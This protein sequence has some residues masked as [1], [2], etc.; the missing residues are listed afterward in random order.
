MRRDIYGE[1]HPATVRGFAN[2]AT[3]MGR[4]GK[5]AEA[6]RLFRGLIALRSRATG[7]GDRELAAFRANLS[8]VLRKLGRLDE[9]ERVAR[10]ALDA[11]PGTSKPSLEA[12]N[13]MIALASLPTVGARPRRS[14]TCATASRS[15][16]SAWAP[17]SPR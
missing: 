16:A 6:E 1:D 12:A 3:T 5:L 11:V 9:A 2:L 4:R 14:A 15:G 7:P 10:Q 17:I 13:T 8:D